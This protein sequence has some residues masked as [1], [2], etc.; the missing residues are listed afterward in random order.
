MLF[1]IA[2]YAL[3]RSAFKKVEHKMAPLSRELA[4]LILS[5]E[6][7]GSQLDVNGQTVDEDFEKSNFAFAGEMRK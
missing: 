5:H 6:N 4:G 7:Y 3:G 1:F 2:T